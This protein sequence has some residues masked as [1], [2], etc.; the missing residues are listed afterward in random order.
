[1][2][3]VKIESPAVFERYEK[4]YIL[5]KE[6]YE[7]LL[8]NL[9]GHLEQDEYGKHTIC[10][11]Y[12][13]TDDYV[14]IRRCLEK[15]KFR[16]KLRLRSYGIP[17]ADTTVFLEL[18]KKLAEITY[19]RRVPLSL[20]DVEKYF[21]YDTP[22]FDRGQ[23]FQEIHWYVRQKPF[24]PKVLISYDR[25][26]LNGIKDPTFRVTFDTDIRWRD[27]DLSLNKGDYGSMLFEP[28]MYLMEVKTLNALPLWFVNIL[29]GLKIYPSSFSKYATIYQEYLGLK[30]VLQNAV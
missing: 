21:T 27:Y 9:N 22:P 13:D 28:E 6:Q 1:M 24:K 10:T 5:K 30:E 8:E 12:Y 17:T 18:K 16:E 26:A 25:I 2:A 7:K 3:K 29:T 23:I 15:P 20:I 11:I 4:K 19:K 14:N